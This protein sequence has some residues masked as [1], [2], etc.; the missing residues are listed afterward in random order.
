MMPLNQANT[1]KRITW[2]AL[3]LG[4]TLAGAAGLS[5]CSDD[6]DLCSRHDVLDSVMKQ[7][8]NSATVAAEMMVEMIGTQVGDANRADKSGH[9]KLSTRVSNVRT[10]SV[11]RDHG[12]ATCSA[13]LTRHYNVQFSSGTTEDTPDR[14]HSSKVTYTVEKADNGDV[15]VTEIKV[16]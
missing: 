9:T 15:A 7:G 3:A 12:R 14:N 2:S 4:L 1:M 8:E 11:D 5:S 10:E 6:R 13:I 16:E